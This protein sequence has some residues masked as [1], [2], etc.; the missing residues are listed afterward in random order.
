MRPLF[1]TLGGIVLL[2]MIQ[3]QVLAWSG[4]GH[5]TVA[6]IAYRQLPEEAREELADL[7]RSHPDF[8][9]WERDFEQKRRGFRD[10]DLG[11][12]LFIRASLW[13]DEIRRT[14][15]RFN[16][17]NWHFVDYP[18]EPPAFS[19]RPRPE[20]DDDVLFG[21]ER[22][23][24][25]LQ[26]RD[27]DPVVRAAHLSWLLH[28]IGD[29]HQPLHCA[30]LIN[31]DFPAPEGDR[32]GNLFFVST[33]KAI[34]LHSFWD[35]LLGSGRNPDPRTALREAIRLETDH[36]RD[37][38]DELAEAE[39]PEDWS[40][41]SRATAV[42]DVYQRPARDDRGRVRTVLL[43]GSRDDRRA[44][45]LPAG[46]SKNAKEIGRERIALAGYRLA[47][48]LRGAGF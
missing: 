29:I 20:P 35:G 6:V 45:P 25:I 18:L 21:I 4:P 7:L 32:G 13:P 2:M 5:A 47:D 41:E 37:E 15:N 39:A 36:P 33:T 42:S 12:Y 24:E 22:S 10:V 46:Y 3:G 9:K 8:R 17:P 40:L 34:K 16:H 28:L 48:H 14:G 30:T 27:E 38:L 31:D 43:R 11:M 19:L 1:R 23:T 44:P 26:D